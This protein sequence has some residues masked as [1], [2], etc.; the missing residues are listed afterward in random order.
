MIHQKTMKECLNI[1]LLEIKSKGL[2]KSVL[3]VNPKPVVGYNGD[4][5]AQNLV[6]VA[7]G[8]DRI[9]LSRILQKIH[10]CGNRKIK[11][12]HSSTKKEFDEMMKSFKNLQ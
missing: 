11:K 2:E 10:G 12:Q 1:I 8:W 4:D 3:M 9:K 6:T 5:F 7:I